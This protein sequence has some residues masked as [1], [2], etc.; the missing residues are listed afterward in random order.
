MELS[1]YSSYTCKRKSRIIVARNKSPLLIGVGLEENFAASDPL[2]LSQLTNEFVFLEDGDVAEIKKESYQVFDG[3]N[4][5]VTRDITEIDIAIN[6]VT[7]GNYSH[8]MEKEIY[9]QPE[10]LANTING[11]LGEDDVLDN[12]FGLGSSEVFS[13]IKRIQFVACGTS[14]HAGKVGRFWF[15]QIAKFPYL[16]RFCK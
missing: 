15:E 5:K 11:K 6:A 1:C 4:S 2:A 16:C 10:S 7:K 9:E 12:I 14:L 3:K 13:K 8:F